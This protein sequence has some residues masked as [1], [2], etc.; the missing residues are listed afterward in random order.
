MKV[1]DLMQVL[2]ACDPEMEVLENIKSRSN[3]I[4]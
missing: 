1:K 4:V 3:K 2:N